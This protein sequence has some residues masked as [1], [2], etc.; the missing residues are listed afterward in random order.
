[1]EWGWVS[2]VQGKKKKKCVA[3]DTLMF[4]SLTSSHFLVQF[5]VRWSVYLAITME[6]NPGRV[7]TPNP[8]ERVSQTCHPQ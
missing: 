6:C 5:P 7:C 8:L 2:E 1:M 4:H 3:K